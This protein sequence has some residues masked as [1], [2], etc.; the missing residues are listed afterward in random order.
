M[1]SIKSIWRFVNWR[2]F[3]WAGLLANIAKFIVFYLTGNDPLANG[4]TLLP[5]ASP[6][7]QILLG[8]LIFMLIGQVF[9]ALVY[10]FIIHNASGFAASEPLNGII[11]AVVAAFFQIYLGFLVMPWIFTLHYIGPDPENPG[12]SLDA[13]LLPWDWGDF[14]LRFPIYFAYSLVM[15]FVYKNPAEQQAMQQTP[16]S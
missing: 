5:D 2:S 9:Y 7:L 10:V 4:T 13:F 15:V 12:Q 14:G 11:K 1:A 16:A 3:L 6:L 8:V